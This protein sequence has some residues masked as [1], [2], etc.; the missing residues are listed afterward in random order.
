MRVCPSVFLL[1]LVLV[2]AVTKFRGLEQCLA[3]HASLASVPQ[4]VLSENEGDNNTDTS[5]HRG[6]GR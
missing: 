4:L 5:P 1:S 6:S 3:E 2:G